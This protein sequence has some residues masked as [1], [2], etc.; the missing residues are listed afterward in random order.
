MQ[1]RYKKMKKI[2]PGVLIVVCI[3]SAVFGLISCGEVQKYDVV[4]TIFPQ[5][6]FVRNIAGDSLSVKMLLPAGTDAHNYELTTRDKSAIANCS[7][8]IYIGG[9]SEKWVKDVRK[10]TNISKSIWL[11]LSKK[12]GL[13]DAVHDH[14]DEHDDHE[15]TFDEHY[16]LSIRDTVDLCNAI[17]EELSSAFPEK[18][19]EFEANCKEYVSKL[20]DLDTLYEETFAEMNDKKA[21]FADRYP[22]A[23]LFRDYGIE[24]DSLFGG[25]STDTEITAQKK[26]DFEKAFS[27]SGKSGVFVLENGNTK[28]AQS[29]VEKCGGKIYTLDSCQTV[30]KKELENGTGYYEKMKKNL[31]VIKE[32]IR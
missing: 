13:M 21:Y 11:D 17:A 20:K 3:I 9:E 12:V 10:S 23:Y 31:D 19:G 29:I 7:V 14:E 1:G 22:F 8:F 5:Y 4:C 6:D 27:L 28:V 26:I 24:C 32:G 16:Y 30:T 15:E 18:K 25:C 2:L